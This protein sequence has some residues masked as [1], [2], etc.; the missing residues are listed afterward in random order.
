MTYLELSRSIEGKKLNQLTHDELAFVHLNERNN[1]IKNGTLSSSITVLLREIGHAKENIYSKNFLPISAAFT[2]LDQL[3]FCY[4]RS[5]MQFD[6][7]PNVSGIK[8]A[9]YYFVETSMTNEDRKALYALRN[10]LLHTASGISTPKFSNQKSYAFILDEDSDV[11]IKYPS[12][13]WNGDFNTL[14]E[15]VWTRINPVI[16]IGIAESAVKVALSCLY[17]G[18]LKNLPGISEK[19]IYHRFLKLNY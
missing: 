4:S 5:D 2:I 17:K 19:E 9:L 13:S 11:L 12:T 3:G 7:D 18:V 6:G 14:S 16:L 8:K 10:S 1:K 15:E